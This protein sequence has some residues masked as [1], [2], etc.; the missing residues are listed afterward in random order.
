[1]SRPTRLSARA[2][3]SLAAFLIL[4]CGGHEGGLPTAPSPPPY[5]LATLPDTPSATTVHNNVVLASSAG[6]SRA[7]VGLSGYAQVGTSS[8]GVTPVANYFKDLLNQNPLAQ[9]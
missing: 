5:D 1:M 2:A 9:K 3:I 8:E 6:A 7:A 4:G